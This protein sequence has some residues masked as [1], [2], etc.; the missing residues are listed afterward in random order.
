MFF[1]IGLFECL[2]GGNSSLGFLGSCQR[3][4]CF[5]VVQAGSEEEKETCSMWS[6]TWWSSKF[7]SCLSL[8]FYHVNLFLGFYC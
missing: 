1:F 4:T 2:F 5:G 8:N 3:H 7:G 6:F